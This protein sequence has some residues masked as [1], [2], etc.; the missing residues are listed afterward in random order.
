MFYWDHKKHCPSLW[1]NNLERVRLET[2]VPLREPLG[3]FWREVLDL[4]GVLELLF[5]LG[6]QGRGRGRE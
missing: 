3:L 4:G 5:G 2:R 6:A 1:G